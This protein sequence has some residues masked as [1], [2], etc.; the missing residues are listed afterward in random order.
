[1]SATKNDGKRSGSIINSSQIPKRIGWDAA[2]QEMA[3]H[4]DDILLI[5][6]FF[7]DEDIDFNEKLIDKRSD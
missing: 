1:M 7:T 4:K 6:D 3:K 2:F 5:P